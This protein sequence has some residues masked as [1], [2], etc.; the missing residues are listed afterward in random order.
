MSLKNN[1]SLLLRKWVII[2]SLISDIS[3]IPLEVFFR[4]IGLSLALSPE[5]LALCALIV[6][7]N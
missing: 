4:S 5:M 2:L 1:Q 7:E 3:H 6:L